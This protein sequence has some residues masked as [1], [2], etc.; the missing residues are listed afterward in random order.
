[1]ACEALPPVRLVVAVA[2]L[3]QKL[4]QS[5]PAHANES[6]VAAKNGGRLDR[7][8]SSQLA[9][10]QLAIE[11]FQTR[12]NS[13]EQVVGT[14]NLGGGRFIADNRFHRPGRIGCCCLTVNGSKPL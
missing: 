3:P 5:R 2:R 8:V 13:I 6:W 7:A 4:S 14:C 1:M 12:Q 9:M 10:D 11:R